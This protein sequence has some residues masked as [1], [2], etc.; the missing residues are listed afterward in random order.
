VT[1]FVAIRPATQGLPYHS[2][3]HDRAQHGIDPADDEPAYFADL[4]L[5][6]LI[7]A[8]T[9]GRE[10][11]DLRPF[12][13][14]PLRSVAAITYRHEALRD[15]QGTALSECVGAFAQRMRSMREQLSQ[16][17]ALRYRYQRERWFLDA[18][19]TYCD[20]VSALA[21]D[22]TPIELRSR[23]FLGFREYLTDYAASDAFT[24]LVAEATELEDR[25]SDVRYCLQ[26]FGGRIKVSRFDGEHDYGAGVAASFEK[27]KRRGVRDYR[28]GFPA[29]VDMNHV[30]AGVLDRV[31][32][33]YPD[34]FS[35]LDSFSERHHDHLDE[36]VG[37]FDREVQFYIAYLEFVDRLEHAGLAFCYPRVSD[38]SKDVSG[39][40]AFDVALADKLVGERSPVVC[41][42]FHLTDP[43]RI[44]VVSGPNQGG[45]TTFART[46]GQMHH[47]ASIGCLVP[48]TEAQL[49]LFDQ[50]FTHFAK[51]ET[52]DDL[53][54]K[55]QDDLLRVHEILE[56]ATADSVVIMNE[57]F[58]STT[59]RDAVFLGTKVL[60]EM[61]ERELLC[62]CV[63][64]VDELASLS[65]VV[66]S[67]VSTV[68]P[69][70]PAVRTFKLV[71]RPADGLSHAL[72]IAETY[73][74]TYDGLKERIT[75]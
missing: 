5:D 72:A 50:L 69:D 63:T 71:R 15:L 1:S 33:L 48:G 3:L 61:I 68:D 19:R 73:G 52:L 8:L 65:A 59:L 13:H 43:E 30:E 60:N 54:G 67:M 7:R 4:N 66:V 36:T 38:R 57:I 18:V 9:A 62:V 56:R 49:F 58:T 28:V 27:F 45:K 29:A 10:E 22:L 23:G 44:F 55:L 32:L 64:F 37:A 26:I 16:A 12:F 11:Y 41:N 74:L 17:A 2:I 75:A 34:T 31:A 20:A 35:T 70:D 47:L 53:S 39:E 46:F 40:G 42:D 6:Q 24:A 25:L 14:T 51:E 21:R